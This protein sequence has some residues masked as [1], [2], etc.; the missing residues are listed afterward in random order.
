MLI[1]SIKIDEILAAAN[2][3]RKLLGVPLLDQL[4][5]DTRLDAG[6]AVGASAPA[7]NKPSA[8][9]DLA[10]MTDHQQR[11]PDLARDEIAKL[12]ATLDSLENDP[13][14]LVSLRRRSLVE[15]GIEL[16]DG[17]HCPLC[18][19]PWKSERHLRDH[20]AAKLDKSK[21]AQRLHAALLSDADALGKA[22]S[23]WLAQLA[24]IKKL[25]AALEDADFVAALDRWMAD[26]VKLQPK[27]RSLDGLNSMRDLL[28]RGW[29]AVPTGFDKAAD[30]F[31]KTIAALPDQTATVDAQTFLATAQIRLG[32]YR[33]AMRADKGA[34]IAVATAACAYATYCEIMDA[35]LEALYDDVQDDFSS[36]YRLINED[37]EGEFT[38]KLSPS[39]GKL[40]FDVNFYE[41]GLYPPGAFHSEG[42]QDSMGVCLYLALMKRVSRI[43]HEFNVPPVVPSIRS[44]EAKK[45]MYLHSALPS[46]VTPGAF[47]AVSNWRSIQRGCWKARTPRCGSDARG[48]PTSRLY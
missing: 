25:A 18:D 40:E 48:W 13:A 47:S 28:V 8:L 35:E 16:L 10:A 32:D 17:L 44:W 5:P 31:A 38:A 27:L 45:G 30:A 37:D 41:R 3:R 33:E 1:P 29:H 23:G 39:A 14:L 19:S 7:C 15:Q 43:K 46:K 26:L 21:E 34:D 12:L 6:L 2:A 22:V 42:H 36:F 4:T 20:L 24:A 9:R 11:L